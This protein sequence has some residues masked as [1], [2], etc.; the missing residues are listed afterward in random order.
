MLS[1]V[2]VL[3]VVIF[4]MVLVVE[5]ALIMTAKIGVTY[6]AFAAVRSA[7]VW[8]STAGTAV[9]EQK[10]RQAAIQALVPFANG[11]RGSAGAQSGTSPG[12]EGRYVELYK[13][14]TGAPASE[15][16]LRSKYGQAGEA[17]SVTVRDRT[18]Q[19][20]DEPWK[21]DLAVTVEFQYAFHVPLISRLYGSPGGTMPIT[22]QCM[23]QNEAPKNPSRSLG[24]SYASH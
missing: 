17:V 24:I 12:A 18:D 16:Y 14:Q 1:Y 9:A 8:Q 23:L 3:P 21:A 11:L 2:M 15:R 4:I 5:T 13:R 22:A 20:P 7:A 19:H 6:A 10:A